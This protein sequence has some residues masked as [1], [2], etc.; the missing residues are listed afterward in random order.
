MQ[1]GEIFLARFPFS[2]RRQV[3][4]R[5]VLAL[6][7]PIGSHDEVLVAYISSVVPAEPLPSDL[8]IDPDDPRHQ[9]TNLKVPSV[10]RLHKLA[11]IQGQSLVRWL[12]EMSDESLEQVRI[13]LWELLAI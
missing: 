10:L 3:K 13:I 6:T 12:G 1:A 2:D 7:P 8:L 9:L 4:L 11:T 5:P